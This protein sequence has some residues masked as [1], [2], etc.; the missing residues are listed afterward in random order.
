MKANVIPTCIP[1]CVRI[2]LTSLVDSRG[3]FVKTFHAS[4]FEQHGL[5]LEIQ[6]EY[7]SLSHRDVLRGMHFQIPPADYV[8]TVCCTLGTVLD[9]V[10]DLRIGSPTYGHHASFLLTAETPQLVYIPS[11]LAHGFRV[12]SE[13]ALIQYQVSCVY[14]PESDRG[15]HWDSCGID[16]GTRTPILSDR[17][18]VHPRLADFVSPFRYIEEVIHS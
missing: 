14:R 10:V 8:K 15:I 11:G 2:Q 18:K 9:A 6:E 5:S 13:E 17:D 12:V 7:Y 4:F 16:W 1:G 3:S